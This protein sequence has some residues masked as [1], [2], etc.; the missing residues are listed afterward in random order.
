DGDV[1]AEAHGPDT[2][3][4]QQLEELLLELRYLGIEIAGSDRPR[5]RLLGEV[6]GVVRGAADSDADDP[7]GARLSAGPDDRLEH[8]LLD[9]AHTVGGDAHLQEAHVLGARTLRDALDVEAVPVG[10]EV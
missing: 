6:H 10:D 9:P 4:V 5:N 1:A 8:E 7:R 2:G 3:L